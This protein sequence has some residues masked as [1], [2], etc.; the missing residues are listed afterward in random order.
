LRDVRV[1]CN[2]QVDMP[3]SAS[4]GEPH[5]EDGH[6]QVTVA[7]ISDVLDRAGHRNQVMHSGMRPVAAAASILGPVFT[8]QAVARPVLSE[9]P[10]EKELEATDAIREGAI[11]VFD[12]GGMTEAG[13]WGELLTMRAQ[14]RGG[15]GAIVD[16]GVRDL[17]GLERLAFPTFAT[18]VHPADSYGRA[19]VI[20]FDAPITCGGVAVHPGDLV[21]ADL[22]GV[23]VIPGDIAADC[24]RE[25]REKLALEEE[26]GSMLRD[27]ASAR[28]MY[29]RHGVL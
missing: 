24:L 27:G 29:G 12:T 6:P 21:A 17:A 28:E 23:V 2:V 8:I 3:G 7:A 25:A 26:A 20:S 19:E 22:D 11:V 4:A 18:A 10:Y 15:I 13:I 1:I 5:A 16:G 14:A 9:R